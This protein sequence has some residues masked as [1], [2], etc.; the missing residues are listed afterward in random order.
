MKD[1]Q[2]THPTFRFDR[3][4]RAPGRG[5]L[6]REPQET[7][8]ELVGDF[9]GADDLLWAAG[10]G[11]LRALGRLRV[12]HSGR[13]GPLIEIMFARRS[14]PGPFAEVMLLAPFIAVVERAMTRGDIAGGQYRARAGVFPLRRYAVDGDGADQWSLWASRAEQ[15]AVANGFPRLVAAG[16]VGAMGELQDN[17]FRHSHKPETGL[18]AYAVM[19]GAF[20]IVVA[21]AGIGV[22]ASLREC[23]DYASLPD[24]GVALQVAVADGNSRFGRDSGGGFGMG[25]IFRAL[26]NHDGELRFRSDD[27]ALTVRGHSPSL[28]GHV[29]LG[30]KARLTGLTI[31]V[32][33]RTPGGGPARR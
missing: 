23:P 24:A 32:L 6:V 31:S 15:A 25:Q 27:H 22:R 29:E 10:S 8:R 13:I 4:L 7:D 14:D 3:E 18:A 20:E 26:A 9:A 17:V 30:H 19:P 33:C 28:Q 21:D 1:N 2:G 11:R 5:A 16:I 12:T